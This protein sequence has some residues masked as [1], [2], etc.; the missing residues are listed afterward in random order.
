MG[1]E[2]VNVLGQC[3]RLGERVQRCV[4]HVGAEVVFRDAVRRHA[5]QVRRRELSGLVDGAPSEQRCDDGCSLRRLALPGHG[6]LH[7]L[8]GT[9]VGAHH[10]EYH[11]LEERKEKCRWLAGEWPQAIA[12]GNLCKASRPAR[13]AQRKVRNIRYAQG[14]EEGGIQEPHCPDL[15]VRRGD[16]P[17]G[18]AEDEGHAPDGDVERVDYLAG[19]ARG[20]VLRRD[21]R[22]QWQRRG[23]ARLKPREERSN[24]DR[25]DA[26]PHGRASDRSGVL[27]DRSH[28]VD[29]SGQVPHACSNLSQLGQKACDD[30]E[31]E[32]TEGDCSEDVSSDAHGSYEARV[33]LTSGSIGRVQDFDRPGTKAVLR[34]ALHRVKVSGRLH[35]CVTCRPRMCAFLRR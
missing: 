24:Q 23:V 4:G 25:E 10:A 2:S 11:F 29:Q 19:L 15:Q 20:E 9:R 18:D 13:R 12:P 26:K 27:R 32:H 22:M 8:A 35:I 6:A 17:T 34:S 16:K 21:G 14:G 1:D 5:A 3:G 31:G 28:Q 30:A 33:S 7:H